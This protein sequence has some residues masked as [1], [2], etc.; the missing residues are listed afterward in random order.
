MLIKRSCRTGAVL[1]AL[2]V[3][4]LQPAAAQNPVPV[5]NPANGHWYQVVLT[6][7]GVTSANATKR[8]V[9]G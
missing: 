1:I 6:P 8:A 5:Y 9:R 3:G 4:A 7:G 2:L